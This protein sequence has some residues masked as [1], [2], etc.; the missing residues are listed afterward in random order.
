VRTSGALASVV[1]CSINYAAR[2]AESRREIS[3]MIAEHDVVGRA[4][5]REWGDRA[6]V[7]LRRFAELH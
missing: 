1:H 7:K 5:A 4:A 3:D 6:E 2:G